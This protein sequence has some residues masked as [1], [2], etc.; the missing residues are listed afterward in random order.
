MH[1]T[2]KVKWKINKGAEDAVVHI[3]QED[4]ARLKRK[5]RENWMDGTWD[6][7]IYLVYIVSA[8][9]VV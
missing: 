9:K 7:S 6:T 8:N 5:D 3:N 1:F 4:I 2:K